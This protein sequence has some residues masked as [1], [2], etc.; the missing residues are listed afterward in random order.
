METKSGGTPPV[1]EPVAAMEINNLQQDSRF[2]TESY[3][4]SDN[5]PRLILDRIHCPHS[6]VDG[7]STR[8]KVR[9]VLAQSHTSSSL[10]GLDWLA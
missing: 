7:S 5:L 4:S 2:L 10:V 6:R 3:A 8:P 9:L 1:C